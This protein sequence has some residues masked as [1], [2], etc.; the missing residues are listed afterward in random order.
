MR[1]SLK[2]LFSGFSISF[3]GALPLGTLN[4]TAF[5][6]AASQSVVSAIWFAIAVVLVELVV[7]R[8]AIYGNEKLTLT[9]R[10]SNYL[11][12]LGIILLLY[13]AILSFMDASQVSE[14]GPQFTALP[15]IGSSFVLGLLLSALNPLHFPFWMTWTKVLSTKGV[16]ERSS[17]SYSFY[18]WGIG[19]GSIIALLIFIFLGKYVFSNYQDYSKVTN[20]FMGLL[21]LGFSLYLTFLLI[22]KRLNLKLQ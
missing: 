2:V 10:V 4:L 16:L 22:K 8:L 21:Y 20:L 11:F 12:P 17:R 15:E 9:D 3:L 1:K 6:I 7:V 14:T 18:I 5:D 13:L 19:V